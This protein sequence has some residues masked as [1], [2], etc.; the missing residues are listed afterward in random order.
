MHSFTIYLFLLRHIYIF[1]ASS[2]FMRVI[3]ETKLQARATKYGI[4]LDLWT[5]L[6]YQFST[7]CSNT[8]LLKVARFQ[9]YKVYLNESST[10]RQIFEIDGPC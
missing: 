10:Y 2:I 6:P 1:D 8:S 9:L 3:N 5:P 7:P 4:A